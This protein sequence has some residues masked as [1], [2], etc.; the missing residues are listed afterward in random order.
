MKKRLAALTAVLVL[1]AGCGGKS[2]GEKALI[3]TWEGQTEMSVL[4][5][6]VENP[7]TV[8]GT[9]SFT[10]DEE[11][12]GILELDVGGNYA[13]I[14]Q[15]FTYTVEKDKLTLQLPDQTMEYT[16]VLDGDALG[17]HGR[18]NFDLKRIA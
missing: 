7:E 15:N 5:E 1:L 14:S 6:G 8:T 10:F 9:V 13:A 4:G 17:L 2:S 12:N 16:F 3:G 11:K 18:A